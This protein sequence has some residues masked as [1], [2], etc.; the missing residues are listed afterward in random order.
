NLHR[1]GVE[2]P[3]GRHH[4]RLW[5]D[6]RPLHT[7]A[8]LAALGLLALP[9]L[10]LLGGRV[11]ALCSSPRPQ[12]GGDATPHTDLPGTD[13]R[14][15]MPLPTDST[16]PAGDAGMPASQPIRIVP[17]IGAVPAAAA[18]LPAGVTPQL[19]YNNG[20]LLANV[21]VFTLFWGSFWAQGDAATLAG[22]INDFFT[23]IVTSPLID[24]LA[25]YQVPA[26]PIGQGTFAGTLT[27]TDQDPAGQVTDQD[28][29]TFLQQQ[30]DGGTVPAV[31]PNLLYFVYVP[32][33][34]TVSL[35][36]SLSCSS[37]CGYHDAIGGN[38]FYAVMPYLDCPGCQ[39]GNSILDGMTAVSSHELCE[40]ITDPIPGQGWY[41]FS[42][43][44]N[45]GEIGDI[46]AGTTKMVG[47][48]TVQQEWSNAAAQCV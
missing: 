21:Q 16:V 28:I 11:Q 27:V 25:E 48:Y 23:F 13:R 12:E 26:F 7:T 14:L 41:W 17:M 2:V 15:P 45:Q 47:P 6:R 36:G 19:T 8:V 40:A 22:Q 9:G 33:G 42:D 31:N 30:I 29:Q 4:V 39:I 20:P 34:V 24:Q 43:P 46:C 5:V 44:A 1:I 18:A 37:F 3:A 35:M 38:V 32:Q 10:A